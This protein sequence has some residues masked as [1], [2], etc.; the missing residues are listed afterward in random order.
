[1]LDT[2]SRQTFVLRHSLVELMDISGPLGWNATPGKEKR[3]LAYS[4]Q[5]AG[6]FI[7]FGLCENY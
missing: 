5:L 6:F 7:I 2:N 3:R 1:M 4:L